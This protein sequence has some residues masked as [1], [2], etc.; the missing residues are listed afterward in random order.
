M[1]SET[2]IATDA[3]ESL[4]R[5]ML[6]DLSRSGITA[7]VAGQLQLRP[8][9]DAEARA[10]GF[11]SPGGPINGY[12]IPFFDP[13]TGGPMLDPKG[14]PYERLKLRT[15]HAVD[16]HT[17]KYLSRPGAGQHAF[18]LPSVHEYLTNLENPLFLVEG[19]KKSIKGTSDGIPTIGLVGNWGFWDS[20]TQDLL[21]ELVPYF[22]PG[23]PIIVVW[24]SDA[25][26]N[27][28][29]S[30]ATQ[31]LATCATLRGCT[32]HVVVLPPADRGG[33]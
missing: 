11:S 23:R 30:E 16:G 13:A 3:L 7:G 14:R 29:F 20:A 2:T 5:W 8:V 21:S 4:R 6:E 12:V 26:T 32:L 17:V 24:D 22:T 27:V 31:R 9:T 25:A 19:E 1:E 10:G 18:I 28:G 15:P 33:E